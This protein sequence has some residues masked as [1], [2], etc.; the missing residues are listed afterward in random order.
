MQKLSL[1]VAV[2]A[3]AAVAA[4]LASTSQ[5]TSRASD[6]GCLVLRKANGVAVI[7]AKGFVLGRFLTGQV[8][9]DDPIEGDGTVKVFGYD[10]K[11]QLTDT[12]TRYSASFGT[13]RF[14]ASGL[15]RLRI[16]AIEIDLSAAG[17]GNATLSAEDF[18]DPGSF[19]VDAESF[20]SAGFQTMPD[21]PKKFII[22]GDTTPR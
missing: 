1:A 9:I 10:R 22:S 7:H 8:E 17:R 15:F 14:R 20:C 16:E 13:I 19:S 4:L 3:A 6:D 21:A 12:K 5:A 11:R 18:F 2:C